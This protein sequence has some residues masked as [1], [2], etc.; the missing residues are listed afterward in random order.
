[1]IQ[2]VDFRARNYD[3]KGPGFRFEQEH[4]FRNQGIDGINVYGDDRPLVM[5]LPKNTSAS[6]AADTAF[7][8]TRTGYQE[9]DLV[10]YDAR[11]YKFN[12]QLSYKIA[13][14]TEFSLTAQYGLAD[15]MITGVDRIA[16]R[17]FEITQYKA[18]LEVNAFC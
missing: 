11:N 16:L 17:D 4:S 2:G 15:A 1:M 5:V 6:D 7:F 8:L 12:A 14:E 9:G 18:E 3:N 10:N 13:P